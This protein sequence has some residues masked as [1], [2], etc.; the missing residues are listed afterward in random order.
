MDEGGDS[1]M[2]TVGAQPLSGLLLKFGVIFKETTGLIPT[3]RPL[4][5]KVTVS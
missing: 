3:E 2:V 1:W 5:A 4:D